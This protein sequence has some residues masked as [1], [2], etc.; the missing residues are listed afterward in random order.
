MYIDGADMRAG[1]GL[2]INS[3][4][5]PNA[6]LNP[7]YVF[8][9]EDVIV[10]NTDGM[11]QHKQLRNMI[12]VFQPIRYAY[13]ACS[14]N[15]YSHYSA[16]AAH[17]EVTVFYNNPHKHEV[18]LNAA[19]GGCF[20]L[21]KCACGCRFCMGDML[22][23]LKWG[24]VSEL[25]RYFYVKDKSGALAMNSENVK[26]ANELCKHTV[27]TEVKQRLDMHLGDVT[28]FMTADEV[29]ELFMKLPLRKVFPP[30]FFECSQ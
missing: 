15:H 27:P 6:E 3:S 22:R 19:V 23:Q 28:M 5:S 8:H 17:E 11:V 14:H 26:S 25:S 24:I 16:I 12:L 30:S 10:R 13:P 1:D 2:F 7:C 18:R 20:P 9:D 21:S 4:C 29:R